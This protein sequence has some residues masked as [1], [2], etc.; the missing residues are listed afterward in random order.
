MRHRE[1]VE[2]G[3][4]KKK[5]LVEEMEGSRSRTDMS[6]FSI[7]RQFLFSFADAD[8]IYLN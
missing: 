5:K 3:E 6:N 1:V 2:V 8:M 4:E 7:A